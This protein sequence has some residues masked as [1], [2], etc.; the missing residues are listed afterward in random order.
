MCRSVCLLVVHGIGGVRQWSPSGF[1]R[2]DWFLKMSHPARMVTQ[3]R[4]R[5]SHVT[6]GHK[7]EDED[8]MPLMFP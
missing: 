8:E 2:S 5:M 3:N 6:N 1:Q 4:R 7:V